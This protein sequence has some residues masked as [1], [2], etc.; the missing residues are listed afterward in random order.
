MSKNEVR[1]WEA[2]NKQIDTITELKLENMKLR[3]EMADKDSVRE[4]KQMLQQIQ[5]QVQQR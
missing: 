2:L 3:M 1:L 5:T 4:L